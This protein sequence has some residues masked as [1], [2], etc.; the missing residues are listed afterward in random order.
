[1]LRAEELARILD[2]LNSGSD[3]AGARREAREFLSA[4]DLAELAQAE[5]ALLQTGLTR[6]DFPRLCAVHRALLEGEMERTMAQVESGHVLHTLVAEHDM[7]LGFL[8]DLAAVNEAI[9]EMEQYNAGR[10]EFAR[11][12]HIAEHLVA[13]EGH[14]RREEEV[15]FPELESRG[16]TGPPQVMRQ[17]HNA[18]RPRKRELHELAQNVA[19]MDFADFKA[20]VNDAVKFIVPTLED[21]IFKE[22]NILYPAALRLIEDEDVWARLKVECDQIGYCCFTPGV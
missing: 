11:L 1:M 18:L 20:R 8:N 12:E 19:R 7:I 16:V 2:R 22:N 21:H 15:L 13:A 3:P 6:R 17:E 4:I 10:E 14:H 9:Q 5:Q